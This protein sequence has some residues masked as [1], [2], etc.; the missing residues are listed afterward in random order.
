[1]AEIRNRLIRDNDGHWFVI[2]AGL[3]DE[4]W[5]WVEWMETGEGPRPSFDFSGNTVDGPHTVTFGEWS[6]GD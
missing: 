2:E 1:M 4:F 5:Q 6:E 3:V